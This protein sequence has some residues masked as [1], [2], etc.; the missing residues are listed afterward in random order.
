MLPL[1]A[2]DPA[3]LAASIWTLDELPEKRLVDRLADSVQMLFARFSGPS[4]DIPRARRRGYQRLCN[5]PRVNAERLARR[6]YDATVVAMRSCTRVV[7]AH[8]SSEVDKCGHAEPQD[9]GPLR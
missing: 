7:L 8:D 9:A 6:A 2:L 4:V 3:E 5:N 1:Y